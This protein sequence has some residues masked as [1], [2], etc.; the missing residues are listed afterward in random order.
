MDPGSAA[1]PRAGAVEG[2]SEVRVRK[3]RIADVQE[4]H[5]II[6]LYAGKQ[7]MLPKAHLQLYENLRDYTVALDGGS[8]TVIGCGALHLYWQ[9][10]AEIRA[11]AV[12]PGIAQ[13]GVGTRV[14]ERLLA[15]AREYGIDQVFVF[16]YV[17]GFFSRFGFIQVEHSAMPLKVFNECF[18]CPKFHTCDEIAMVLHL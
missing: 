6:N 15:E 5:R 10:L 17:P 8:E 14:V 4:M 3:A 9:D 16:T 2:P 11:V 1:Q 12:A 13:R 7:L 18:H